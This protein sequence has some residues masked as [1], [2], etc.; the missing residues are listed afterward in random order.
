MRFIAVAAVLFLGLVSPARG[1]GLDDYKA[2][3]NAAIQG[4]YDRAI[5]LI[6]SAV[7]SGELSEDNR[8]RAIRDRDILYRRAGH[9]ITVAEQAGDVRPDNDISSRTRGF[10]EAPSQRIASRAAIGPP[11]QL[12][13][14]PRS[15]E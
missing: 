9:A 11:R 7:D 10:A 14:S 15:P 12:I 4:N 5:E 6:T 13:G 3:F 1:G 2:G 8:M